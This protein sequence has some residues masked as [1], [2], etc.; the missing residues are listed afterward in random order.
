VRQNAASLASSAEADEV[1]SKADD[2]H[3]THSAHTRFLARAQLGVRSDELNKPD[4][5]NLGRRFVL[6]GRGLHFHE[7]L[8]LQLREITLVDLVGSGSK[9]GVG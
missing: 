5:G 2:A 1:W 7:L 9:V 6:P 4:G 8:E 3:D